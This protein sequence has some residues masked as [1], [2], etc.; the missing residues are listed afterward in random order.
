M[1][2]IDLREDGFGPRWGGYHDQL[3]P[4]RGHQLLGHPCPVQNDPV[5][6][7]DRRHLLSLF[8]DEAPGWCWGDVGTLFFSVPEASLAAGTLT[9]GVRFEMQ[10]S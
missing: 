9:E 3:A 6:G 5:G 10:C 7:K 8:S 4:Q 2:E 1:D